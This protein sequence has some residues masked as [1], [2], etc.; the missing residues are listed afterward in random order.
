MQCAA[1]FI[2]LSKA[3]DTV[4]HSLLLRRLENIGCDSNSLKWFHNYLS[5]RQQYV[6]AGKVK[7][8]PLP[9]TNGVPQGSI[10][11][12]VFFTIYINDIAKE[13]KNCN[14]HLYAD[15]TILYCWAD[16]M[17]L[18]FN[19]LQ[20]AFNVLQNALFNLKLVLN[21]DKTKCMAFTRA[22]SID[23]TN[24]NIC[25]LNGASLERVQHYKYLGIWIDDKF[26]FKFHVENLT[27]CLRAKLGLLYRHKSCF[28][29]FCRKRIVEAVLLSV[30]DYGDIIY[31]HA[32]AT[33]LKPLDAIYHSA[34]RFIT[35][36]PYN[37]H[38]CTLYTTVGWPSLSVRR[39][40]HWFLYIY[41]AL[42]KK[43]PPYRGRH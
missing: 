35:G 41:K 8:A 40:H 3:F 30:F 29:L 22:N 4:N 13:V 36:N 20:L 26:T 37:T 5:D 24:L 2:D 31:R 11:G 10:L 43:S 12:P 21:S 39:D 17:T 15:D 27:K 23:F 19:N 16:S 18:A 33:T 28:P 14:I 32:A 1:L 42:L 7:S 34:L 9:I 25:T 6:R 38:H